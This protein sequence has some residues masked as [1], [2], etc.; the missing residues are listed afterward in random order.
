MEGCEGDFLSCPCFFCVWG[1]EDGEAAPGLTLG[2]KLIPTGGPVDT[3]LVPPPPNKY[4]VPT[5]PLPWPKLSS[6]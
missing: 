5:R 1:V 2:D 3:Y 4:S 6:P